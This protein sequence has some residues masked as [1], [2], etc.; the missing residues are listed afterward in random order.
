MSSDEPLQGIDFSVTHRRLSG[1]PEW[2]TSR[3]TFKH[4]ITGALSKWAIRQ[5]PIG[6]PDNLERVLGLVNAC[7]DRMDIWDILPG[8]GNL[9]L[10][11][12]NKILH[13][14]LLDQGIKEFDDWNRSQAEKDGKIKDPSVLF[15]SRY[16]QPNPYYD[17]ID[18]HA[19]LHNVCL[20]IRAERRADDEF[21][22]KFE[23]KYG[24]PKDD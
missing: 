23:E 21:D 2:N 15:S 4:E 1:D 8:F 10:C 6:I 22:R 20:D 7:L 5:A 11:Q 12:I 24:K 16:S 18:L 17:F 19:L 13:D 3:P 9:S 14:L